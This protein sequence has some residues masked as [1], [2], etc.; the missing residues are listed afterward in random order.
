MTFAVRNLK[1]V[2]FT[3]IFL[4]SSV[5]LALF[6]PV[7]MAQTVNA[8]L[9]GTV[10]DPTQAR[11]PDAV[12]ELH[13]NKSSDIRRT[14]S[15]GEGVYSFVA[16]PPGTYTLIVSRKG[17]TSERLV[18]IE[19]HPTD[20]RVLDVIL[21][22]GSVQTEVVVN[23]SDEQS[24]TGQR[25]SLI[26][27]NDVAHLSVQ[28]RDV[29]ELVKDQAGFAIVSANGIA[30]GTYDPGQVS[31][32][33][34]LSNFVA[35]GSTTG[36]S[37]ISDGTDITDPNSGNSTTQN[38]NQEMVQEVEI[39]TSAFG[40]DQAKGPI[41]LNAVTKS[42]G[43]IY[44]GAIY[45]YARTHYLNSQNWFSKNQG[46]P[47]APDRYLYPGA[48]IGG[49]VQLPFTNFNKSKR[50]TFFVGAEDYVQRNVYAYNSALSSSI[51]ALVPTV[52]MRNGNFSQTELANY[53]GTDPTTM[54]AQCN[55]TGNLS[56]YIHLC[57]S[58]TGITN[59]GVAVPSTGIIPQTGLDPG[60]VALFNSMPLP[61]RPSAGGF[62]YSTINYV[63]NDMW[64][65]TARIDDSIS[66]KLKLSISYNV[67]HGVISGIPEI[68]SYSPGS[69]GPDMGGLDTPGKSVSRVH[70]QS[71]SVNTTYIF[72]SHMTNEAYVS[73][74][75][76]KTDFGPRNSALLQASTYGY[77]YSGMYPNAT[78]Q[79]PQFGDYGY[80]GLPIALYPDFSA[81]K[82]FQHAFSP[83][84][85]DN[86]TVVRGTHTAKL[87][88]YIQR[89]TANNTSPAQTNGQ[90]NIYYL[91]NGTTFTNPD[92]T[93][94]RTLTANTA[95]NY[96][97][98]FAIGDIAQ[99]MQQNFSTNLNIY[100]WT[101]SFFATDSWKI[102]PRLTLTYGLRFDHLGPWE[103]A[104]G[105]GIAV[106]NPSIYTNPVSQL[107]P[108]FTWHA[109]DP[110]VP[111]SGTSSRLFFY[112]PRAGLAYDLYGGG[113]TIL[114]GGFG[115]YRSHDAGGTYQQAV[116]TAQGLF[117]ATAGGG[118][119]IQ[120]S[121]LQ[122]GASSLTD[123]VNNVAG[124]T[125]KCPS[126]NAV[127]YG[128]DR[129]DDEQPLTYT[130][131][132][133][134]N[135]KLWK[136]SRLNLAYAGS[137]SHD[138]LLDTS[139]QNVDALPVG[140]LLAIDPIT[141]TFQPPSALSIAQ[142][143]DYRPYHPY[144]AVY[145]GRH[146]QY[147]NYNSLQAS[148]SRASG[149]LRYNFNF[150]WSK[151]LGIH[152]VPGQ[153]A[154]PTNLRN[155]YGYMPSDRTYIFNATYSYEF[156][157]HVHGNRLLAGAANG[158]EI[159][160]ITGLQS[161]PNLA[162]VYSPDFKLKGAISGTT[163]NQSN[164]I[165]TPD[166][167]LQPE[168]ICDPSTNLKAK[169]YV[170]GACFRMPPLGQN[171]TFQFPYLHGPAYFNTDLTI[172]K[173]FRM[174]GERS[175]QLRFAGFNFLNHPITSFSGRFPQEANLYFS[176]QTAASATTPATTGN[177]SVVGS[178]CFG[179]AGYKQGRRVIEV[180]AKL[181]F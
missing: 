2:L 141:H 41:V 144:Q 171:G 76:N 81:G 83:A 36:I 56:S 180:A 98:D 79:I 73:A 119:G 68:Q 149:G 87:G 67:E 132:F 127:V 151:N 159:S 107:L 94:G 155:D 108:G 124:L 112:S 78:T 116:G 12:V 150:T 59:N 120:M 136:N 122:H 154:D 20:T 179:Y 54:L 17:F 86:F 147:S 105:N 1:V 43:F 80:N 93:T 18:K 161:G 45:T 39:N 27:A 118:A 64:Q 110:S 114:Q 77:P 157:S 146:L 34:G 47:D 29:S 126:L 26:S 145:V 40:A 103:D 170:N 69:G 111:N 131:N 178:T 10:M 101:S 129:N 125:S 65:L 84:F 60:A 62:N 172:L 66:D 137:Q 23:A 19:L 72:N 158:W 75:L 134:V 32:S 71:L 166:I 4:L 53:L 88:V 164:W 3:G 175:L 89:V 33:G 58:P 140:A 90:M 31:T 28:G 61:N 74:A 181:T 113:R 123:C 11:I 42:G 138:L 38:I 128:V 49:P 97:A 173:N 24:N 55:L 152:T 174:S 25:S 139:L 82:Y 85:G 51:L 35:N 153:Y 165:G 100:Y 5:G 148:Y 8:T 48:N 102:T 162:S 13:S 169:Q 104:H 121:H 167:S 177:C 176:G 156:G 30:N 91:P 9:S 106:F 130:Y 92:G 16:I 7:L 57:G 160:G 135:Q 143:G 163:I 142:Q 70:A 14:R 99:F 95:A 168:L 50:M 6:T 21:N 15:N 22:I 46:I 117:L 109:L 44:H 96:L 52:N 133:S 37:V 63:N 115:L